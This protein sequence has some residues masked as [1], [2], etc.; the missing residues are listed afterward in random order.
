MK[1]VNYLT[2]F[3]ALIMILGTGLVVAQGTGPRYGTGPRAQQGMGCPM[4]PQGGQGMVPGAGMGRCCPAMAQNFNLTDAQIAGMKEINE[5]TMAQSKSLREQVVDK[6]KQLAEL[7]KT[8][9]VNAGAIKVLNSDI[10]VIYSQLYNITVDATI[11]QYNLLNDE[12][13]QII[14]Q[15]GVANCCCMN[16]GCCGAIACCCV[17]GTKCDGPCLVMGRGCPKMGAGYG[18]GPKEGTGPRAQ[19]GTCPIQ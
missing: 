17:T 15:K 12:Q 10:N 8:P 13:K 2:L 1:K 19:Q 18:M 16:C 6:Q 11:A 5:R 9:D 4:M 7:W 3:L 14:A